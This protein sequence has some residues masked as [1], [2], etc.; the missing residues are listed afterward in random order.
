MNHN[1][2]RTTSTT[3]P[4]TLRT[5]RTP[6]RNIDSESYGAHTT[7]ASSTLQSMINTPLAPYQPTA[8]PLPRRHPSRANTAIHDSDRPLNASRDTALRHGRESQR[9]SSNSS[10]TF[11]DSPWS[12]FQDLASQLLNGSDG[13][14]ETVT[15]RP[16]N[17]KRRPLAAT[18]DRITSAPPA[19]WGPSGS[20]GK[21]LGKGSKED[22]LAHVQA[23]KREGLLAAN[24]HVLPD[25]TGRFKRRGSDEMHHGSGPPVETE[26]RDAL[27]YLH[28]VKPQDTLAGVMIKYN[29]EPNVFRKA[30]RLWPNDSIQIRKVVMLPVEA[31]GIKGRKLP[32]AAPTPEPSTETPD[33]DFMPTPTAHRPPWPSNTQ[34]QH[35]QETPF[36]SVP[37]SPS[38][39]VTGPPEDSEPPWKHDSWVTIDGFASAV[40]IARL[41]RRTLGFFPRSRRKSQSNSHSHSDLGNNNNSSPPPSSLDLPRL[42]LQSTSFRNGN[43]SRSS[44]TANYPSLSYLH[45][46][47]GVGTLGKDV[48]GPGP[49]PDGLNK[50]FAAHLPSVAPRGDSFESQRSDHSSSALGIE[51][52]GGA[53]EG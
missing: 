29:C 42:S 51:N 45:G 12:S 4:N 15:S 20:A 14:E 17:R 10:S 8:A 43:K 5:R 47:G 28:P 46:P 24:G 13:S 3:P 41:P 40:E 25:T 16:Q 31:C 30:N 21:S 53:I 18:H 23:K 19:Q 39:S 32:D 37:S 9:T 36:S 6:S 26:D 1:A 27:V 34:N 33:E 49:A 48:R 2:P 35:P 44:S 7:A 22:R 11:W 52:V 50:L 38:I